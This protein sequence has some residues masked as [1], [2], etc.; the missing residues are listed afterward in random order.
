MK[1]K[2]CAMLCM[3][4]LIVGIFIGKTD[5]KQST[6]HTPNNSRITI[7]LSG[8]MSVRKGQSITTNLEPYHVVIEGKGEN[9]SSLPEDDATKWFLSIDNGRA[10]VACKE[11][12]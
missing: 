4:A 10:L 8:S 6:K 11:I 7:D 12:P 5:A 1:T 2:Y 3:L 9:L